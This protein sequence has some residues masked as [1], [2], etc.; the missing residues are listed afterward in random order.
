M[1]PLVYRAFLE[2]QQCAV[3]NSL[4]LPMM[5]HGLYTQLMPICRAKQTNGHTETDD[6]TA[7]TQHRTVIVCGIFTVAPAACS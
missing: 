4:L 2:V 3:E 6:M 7:G 1:Q 5:F